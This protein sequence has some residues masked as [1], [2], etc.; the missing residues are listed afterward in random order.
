MIPRPGTPR[1]ETPL[2]GELRRGDLRGDPDEE[3]DGVAGHLVP[4]AG[5]PLA[6]DPRAGDCLV[7]MPNILAALSKSESES[8]NLGD[9]L[10]AKVASVCPPLD[11]N[12]NSPFSSVFLAVCL[13]RAIDCE[14][15]SPLVFESK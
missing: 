1:G 5:D 13:V 3:L 10:F 15:T 4:R 12:G 7:F 8:R 2:A 14:E 9:R 11:C 6:E